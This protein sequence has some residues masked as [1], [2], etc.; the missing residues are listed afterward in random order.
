MRIKLA[1]AAITVAALTVVGC[2]S[3]GSVTVEQSP[4]ACQVEASQVPPYRVV[5]EDGSS[6]DVPSGHAQMV[7]GTPCDKVVEQWEYDRRF[8]GYVD[9][10]Q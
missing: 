7:G 5:F 4:S 8:S 2:Q 6:V 9:L 1:F 10:G 3:K